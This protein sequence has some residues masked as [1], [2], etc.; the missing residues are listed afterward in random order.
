MD[1]NGTLE[2]MIKELRGTISKILG[3]KSIEESL[4][5]EYIVAVDKE[6]DRET[7]EKVAAVLSS[8]AQAF[9]FTL[10]LVAVTSE[11]IKEAESKYAEYVASQTQFKA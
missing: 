11:E 3:V 7:V 9:G 10:D 8:Q 4:S 6:E 1:L 2:P 5:L